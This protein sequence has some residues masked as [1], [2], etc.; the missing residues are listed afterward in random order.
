MRGL[1]NWRWLGFAITAAASVAHVVIAPAAQAKTPN[2]WTQ[3]AHDAA[4][5]SR[6]PALG[7]T[8]PRIAPGWP[9]S[10]TGDDDDSCGIGPIVAAVP[11]PWSQRPVQTAV[12]VRSRYFSRLYAYDDHGRALPGS[13]PAKLDPRDWRAVNPPLQ[14]M[15][16]TSGDRL[17]V[18]VPSEGTF[19]IDELPPVPARM[20]ALGL[21]GEVQPGGWPWQQRDTI[22]RGQATLANRTAGRRAE[23]VVYV[24]NN[25]PNAPARLHAVGP[26]G[27]PAD[28]RWPVK[29]GYTQRTLGP[30]VASDGTVYV[31]SAHVAGGDASRSHW[32]LQ[33]LTPDGDQKPGW[34]YRF[35]DNSDYVTVYPGPAVGDDGTVYVAGWSVP[36]ATPV[37]DEVTTYYAFT[38]GGTVKPGWP[39]RFPGMVSGTP[40]VDSDGT[41]FVLVKDLL[42]EHRAQV[43]VYAVDPNGAIKRG[44][45]L[46]FPVGDTNDG[47]SNS[48]GLALD[49]Y[50]N[51]FFANG[52]IIYGYSARLGEP[53]ALPGWPMS[54]DGRNLESTE[55]PA[56]SG[57]GTLYFAATYYDRSR[58]QLMRSYGKLFAVRSG[59]PIRALS[60]PQGSK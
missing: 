46:R 27:T 22:I 33:A 13:W 4:H 25:E 30:A 50:G 28:G 39:V 26:D 60:R 36:Y 45:P 10:C 55:T 49:R 17:S 21:D 6:S 3:W 11:R 37:V 56:L 9:V 23:P 41:T 14:P 52:P 40:A 47:T 44:W 43:S 32:T 38:P 42:G 59:S 35:E 5:T 2:D 8:W 53:R 15:V 58:P 7:P 20:Y 19:G 18:F 34:P 1:M 51:L 24:P 54:I 48:L 57:D 12:F 16:S 29:S 31:V